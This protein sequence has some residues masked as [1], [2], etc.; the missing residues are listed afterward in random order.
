MP[1]LSKSEIQRRA[2]NTIG[3]K[4][5]PKWVKVR[6]KRLT[7]SVFGKV[8]RLI[9]AK[10]SIGITKFKEEFISQTQTANDLSNIPAIKWGLDHEKQAIIE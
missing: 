10:N 4:A 2:A 3:Q 7:A 9:Q 1:C 8:I 6:Q 5:N